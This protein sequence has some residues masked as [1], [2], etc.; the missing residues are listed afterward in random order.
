VQ[1]HVV[2]VGEIGALEIMVQLHLIL[3]GK[4]GASKDFGAPPRST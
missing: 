1:L 4:L 3:V 2:L